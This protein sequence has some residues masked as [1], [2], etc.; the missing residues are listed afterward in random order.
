MSESDNGLELT[1]INSETPLTDYCSGRTGIL[2]V[3]AAYPDIRGIDTSAYACRGIVFPLPQ[4]ILPSRYEGIIQGQLEFLRDIGIGP[5]EVLYLDIP[6][7]GTLLD[8]GHANLR[9]T[10]PNASLLI[11]GHSENTRRAFSEAAPHILSPEATERDLRQKLGL[12]TTYKT[13]GTNQPGNSKALLR[14]ML[15]RSSARNMKF[16]QD[17]SRF[18]IDFVHIP[19][20]LPDTADWST[21]VEALLNKRGSVIVK[22]T[23]SASG[24]R[25]GFFSSF[26]AILSFVNDARKTLPDIEFVVEEDLRSERSR[27]M[28]A[29]YLIGDDGV[30]QF[31]SFTENIVQPTGPNGAPAAW[32][33]ALTPDPK[34][35]INTIL[36]PHRNSLDLIAQRYSKLGYRGYMSLDLMLLKDDSLKVLEANLRLTG[37]TAPLV[38]QEQLLQQGMPT[39]RLL[40]STNSIHLI[41]DAATPL[42][43]LDL[44]TRLDSLLYDSQT[45][46]GVIPV[47]VSTLPDKVGLVVVARDLEGAR[48]ILQGA[49]DALHAEPIGATS[50]WE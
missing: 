33:N 21:A 28:S 35:S 19:K 49:V 23:N 27:E 42:T 25:I 1:G 50:L 29:Q 31:L 12:H 17:L 48:N 14:R 13:G 16:G 5:K 8:A 10:N 45:H 44:Q 39:D 11:H 22:A 15:E 46:T 4:L 24:D 26:A 18:G 37:A 34:H 6:E 3:A 43:F 30:P 38:I 47:L 20:S 41:Q 7:G 32:G 36:E 2:D 40:L 9:P